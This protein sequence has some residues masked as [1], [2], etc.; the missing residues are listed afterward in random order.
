MF[1]SPVSISSALAMAFKGVK[2]NIM[3]QTIQALSLSQSGGEVKICNHLSPRLTGQVCSIH[4]ELPTGSLQKS[5][6]IST[7]LSKIPATNSTK[8]RWKSYT[9]SKLQRGL[10]KHVNT[11]VANKM[12]GKITEQL[13]PAQ[14]LRL[15]VWF[16]WKPSVSKETW[17]T[18]LTNNRPRKDFLNQQEWGETC[19]KDVW[20]IFL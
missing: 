19:A 20:E 2:G 1:F 18:S 16:A 5:R 11:W 7:H 3:A 13:S 4:L 8:Q 6:M 10:E 15:L 14:L 9:S 12:E 17:I